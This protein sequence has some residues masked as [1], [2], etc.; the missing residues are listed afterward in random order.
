MS[1]FE[2]KNIGISFVLDVLTFLVLGLLLGYVFSYIGAQFLFLNNYDSGLLNQVD[3][4]AIAKVKEINDLTERA[5]KVSLVALTIFFFVS[6]IIY[7][8]TRYLIFMVLKHS[9]FS[10]KE[11]GR[12]LWVSLVWGLFFITLSVLLYIAAQDKL[13][14]ILYVLI[15]VFV[16][17]TSFIFLS[18]S[19][20][21]TFREFL[22]YFFTYSIKQS[23]TLVFT[24]AVVLVPFA[25]LFYLTTLLPFS[26]LLTGLIQLILFAFT[27]SVLRL[28]VFELT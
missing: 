19:K 4:N 16:Y 11:Y 24:Y 22:S 23:Y 3:A 1:L 28:Y 14:M 12:Y 10:F 25:L 6:S 17:F 21:K 18:L 8:F 26:V 2:G 27:V 9:S 7:S 20:S 5:I 15:P 13:F